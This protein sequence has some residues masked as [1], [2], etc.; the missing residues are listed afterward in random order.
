MARGEQVEG[1]EGRSRREERCANVVGR[2]TRRRQREEERKVEE[3][4]VE[5][6]VG[7]IINN[8]RADGGK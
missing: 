5:V 3:V 7:E 8:S 6:Q 1:R 2:R 4:E